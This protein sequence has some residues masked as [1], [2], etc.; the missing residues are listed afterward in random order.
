[1]LLI[2]W[3]WLKVLLT[4]F[5]AL[6]LYALCPTPYK[7]FLSAITFILSI[8]PFV[9][10][11]VVG[12]GKIVDFY[13][14]ISDTMFS[15]HALRWIGFMED[16][17]VLA[18]VVDNIPTSIN[19]RC[20]YSSCPSLEMSYPTCS[21]CGTF[22]WHLI[23]VIFI[24]T[25]GCTV[26]LACRFSLIG[27]DSLVLLVTWYQTYRWSNCSNVKRMN[28]VNA[29]LEV[30][31]FTMVSVQTNITHSHHLRLFNGPQEALISCEWTEIGRPEQI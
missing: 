5:S 15:K 13:Y 2:Y 23:T 27:A 18:F 14:R 1:M 31:S 8:V 30:H 17:G 24:E 19:T 26:T 4:A 6:R 10:N 3:Y 28:K 11:M 16:A 7:L 21:R 9:L 22:I 20:V 29:A 25:C 12:I